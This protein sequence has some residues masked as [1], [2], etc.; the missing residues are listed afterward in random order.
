VAEQLRQLPIDLDDL[1][2]A[3]DTG[4]GELSWFLDAQTG[5][6]I[7]VNNEYDPT[8]TEGPSQEE[9]EANPD[10]YLQIPEASSDQGYR[11]M[12]AFIASVKDERFRE[13]LEIAILGPGPFRRFKS[14]L[15]H[16]PEQRELWFAFKKQRM[17]TRALE[18][19]KE[20]GIAPVMGRSRG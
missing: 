14:V 16:V 10:R 17:L 8:D 5:E 2:I 15:N 19:L 11:D 7:L 6:T 20:H 4:P 1:C 9:I 13:S 3:L 12:Q 18:W